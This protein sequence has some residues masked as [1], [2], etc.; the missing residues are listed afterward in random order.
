MKKH[1]PIPADWPVQPVLPTDPAD[2][3]ATDGYCG[4]TWDDGKVTSMTPA[5]SGRCPFEA[6]H[7]YP[8]DEGDRYSTMEI[9]KENV[10]DLL[11]NVAATLRPSAGFERRR[12][13]TGQFPLVGVVDD[14]AGGIVAYAIGD[15]HAERI[16][17]ALNSR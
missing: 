12:D 1:E 5:P 16:A 17:A 6:F 14:E 3:P 4:L 9:D 10:A 7:V 2:D 11:G 8:E 13:R 15:E